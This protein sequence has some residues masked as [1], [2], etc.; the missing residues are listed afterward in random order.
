[1]CG[2]SG[3]LDYEMVYFTLKNVAGV[4]ISGIDVLASVFGDTDDNVDSDSSSSVPSLG[5]SDEAVVR[6]LFRD[7]DGEARRCILDT[8]TY[9]KDVSLSEVIPSSSAR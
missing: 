6:V 1:M 7:F 2:E 3:L 5:P 9:T 8:L 4:P